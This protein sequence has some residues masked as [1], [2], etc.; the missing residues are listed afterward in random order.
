MTNDLAA[1]IARLRD[2]LGEMVLPP[3]P[4]GLALLRDVATNL[5]DEV[6]ELFRHVGGTQPHYPLYL[7]SAEKVVRTIQECREDIAAGND[8]YLPWH[9]GDGNKYLLLFDDRGS[10]FLGIHLAAPLAP[11]GFVLDHD[12]PNA[13]PQFSSLA[14]MI[15]AMCIAYET[16]EVCDCTQVRRDYPRLSPHDVSAE[17]RILSRQ[18]LSQHLNDEDDVNAA[19]SAIQLSDPRDMEQLM[20]LLA[21]DDMWISARVCE[22][23]GQRKYIAGIARMIDATVVGRGN[24]ISASV[25]ALRDWNDERAKSGLR[26]LR[27]RLGADFPDYYLEYLT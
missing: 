6:I 26:A 25:V 14:T 4:S 20:P 18:L 17:D 27:D 11:R 13:D 24:R 15:D 19:F 22:L 16:A 8:D 5:P 10:N 21:S 23:I 2:K 12:E 1:S 3:D 9:F 7:M